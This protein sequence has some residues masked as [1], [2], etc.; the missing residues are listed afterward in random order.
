MKHSNRRRWSRATL[1]GV[2]YSTVLILASIPITLAQDTAGVEKTRAVSIG[3]QPLS[4]ALVI[5][6]DIFEVSIFGDEKLIEGKTTTPVSGRYS[7]EKALDLILSNS[8]LRAQPS[9]SGGFVLVQRVADSTTDEQSITML[10]TIQVV[11]REYA[12]G[13]TKGTGYVSPVIQAGILGDRADLDTPFTIK[14]YTLD[15]IEA[16]Q[17]RTLADILRTDA[18]I[19]NLTQSGGYASEVEIRGFQIFSAS[20]DGLTGGFNS[21][22]IDFPLEFV[23]A[24]E[25]VKGPSALLFGASQQFGSPAG[26]VNY[27]PKRAPNEGTIRKVSVGTQT[28][29]LVSA[30]ADLGGRIGANDAFGYRI[31]VVGKK[32]D[33]ALDHVELDEKGILAS[34]DWR[35]TDSLVLIAEAGT[36]DSLKTGYPAIHIL[37]AGVEVPDAPSGEIN[38][39]QPWAEW[40]ADREFWLLKADWEFVPGWT[41]SLASTTSDK[42]FDFIEAVPYIL[43]AQG[44][45][46][47]N[48]GQGVHF[49]ENTS[50]QVTLTGQIQTGE[51]VHDIAFGHT[52]DTE[53]AT[54]T[55]T[56]SFAVPSIASNI[57][58]PVYIPKP[59]TT[60]T[61]TASGPYTDRTAETTRLVDTISW[62]PWS[63]MLGVAHVALQ[64]DISGYDESAT[65]PM[66]A[67]LY[68]IDSSTSVYASYAEGFENGGVAPVAAANAFEVMP[69]RES[70]Q[71]ELGIK[72]EWDS[73][74]LAAALFRIERTLEF[75]DMT[76]NVYG[77]DGVQRHDGLEMS[78]SGQVT[79]DLNL[80]ASAMILD[81]T[82]DNETFS[83]TSPTGI[84]KRSFSLY[85]DY[86]LPFY[87][88]LSVSAGIQYKSSQWVDLANTQKIDSYT[89]FDLG[90]SLDMQSAFNVPGR[91]RLNIDNATDEAYWRSVS[92]GGCCLAKGEPRVVKLSASFKF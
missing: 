69:P 57:Y 18:S 88:P 22:Y 31:N 13:N 86:R 44:N 35:V 90:A 92:Y 38:A 83:G 65:T 37:N 84:P 54:F 70:S 20:W 24:V 19:K 77:Q 46:T 21:G 64:D 63:A 59:M 89:V 52:R 41:L 32:G 62:G 30:S 78:V 73:L 91:L 5:L 61:G 11:G 76:T 75:T 28:G 17:A 34:F 29:G 15:L 58:N 48:F 3:E 68:K 85:A 60:P 8:D 66:G 7:I 39:S 71:V 23:D 74:A 55:N 27:V 1:T 42:D 51:L 25:V 56:L 2:I 26:L 40:T 4:D 53:K 14:S 87:R 50:N 43:D 6:S 16:Q 12:R 79:R 47:V 33:L 45:S 36:I 72:K 67:L 82:V 9:K 81:G 49:V 10:P 80:I